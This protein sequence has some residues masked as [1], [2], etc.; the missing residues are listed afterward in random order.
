[1][2]TRSWRVTAALLTV[3]APFVAAHDFFLRPTAFDVAAD[4][5]ITIPAL[6]GTFSTSANIVGAERLTALVVVRN[7]VRDSLPRRAWGPGADSTA[8]VTVRTGAPGRLVV[9]VETAPRVLALDGNAFNAYLADDGI[10]DELAA[11]RRDG[12]ANDSTRESYA[13]SAKTIL[14]VGA[15]PST[16]WDAQLGHE[17]ELVP[18][19]DPYVARPGQRLRLRALSRGAPLA[20]QIVVAG[21]RR[22]DGTRI[23]AQT[24]RTDADGI[25]TIRLSHA[26]QWYAKFIRMRRTAPGDTLTHESRWASLTFGIR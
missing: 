18:L 6:N 20:G 19:R 11:R 12:T 16:G 14:R 5:T 10:P 15:G 3:A 24:V 4:T 21:G 8:Q 7:G 26:G 23:P 25:A 17:V 13:K 2:N 9:G 22:T 1:M